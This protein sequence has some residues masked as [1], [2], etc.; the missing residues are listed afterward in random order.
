MLSENHY[1][2][3][4]HEKIIFIKNFFVFYKYYVLGHNYRLNINEEVPIEIR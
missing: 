2:L 4:L 3:I 1:Q